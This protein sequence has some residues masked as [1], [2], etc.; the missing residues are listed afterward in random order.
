MRAVHLSLV[1][2]SLLFLAVPCARAQDTLETESGNTYQ[3]KVIS[4]DGTAVE[5]TTTDGATMKIPYAQLTPMT[6]YRLKLPLAG[7]DGKKILELA[8]WCVDKTLY[9]EARTEFRRALKVA[10][11]MEDEISKQF[12]AART[13]AANE[14]LARGKRLQSEKKPQEAREV[15]SVVVRELPLE[16]ASKEAAQLLAAETAQRKQDAL[17]RAPAPAPAAEDGADVPPRASGEPFSDATKHLFQS[18]ISDYHEMLD[19]TQQGLEKGGSNGIAEFE[20]ALK[21]GDKI[22][23]TLAG[24]RSKGANDAEITEA[25]QLADSK[26]EEAIV[27]ARINMAD[28][29]ML[30]TSYNQASEAVRRGLAEYPKNARLRQAMD[31]VTAASSGDDFGWVLRG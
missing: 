23:S 14:L 25:L 22:R 16:N 11:A 27:D 2:T 10:P 5:I 17:S 4:N 28:A 9:K 30:R 21:D 1:A 15:L 8:D 7:D 3:G 26:L 6:Q 29:Y 13:T 12:A 20:K 19:D 18:V 24:L 31:R